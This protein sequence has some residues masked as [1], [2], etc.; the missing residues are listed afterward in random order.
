LRKLILKNYLSPGD[1]L[2][3]T[4][5]VR[6]LHLSYPD[7][8]ITDVRT[9]CPELWENN[10][11]ITELEDD[12]PDVETIECEYPL[13][14]E[15]N[16][17]PF[18]FIH[19]FR[20]FLCGRLD[21]GIK[22]T[23]FKGDVHLSDLEKSW[24]SQVDEYTSMPGTRFWIIVSG[25][26]NDF[27][28]KWWDPVRCQQVVDHFRDR[29][30]FVQCGGGS[31]SHSHPPLKGVINFVGQTDLRQMVRL[32]YHADGVVCP[33]TM[34][35]HLA[36]A[37]EP[38][39]GRPKNRACVVLAGGREPVQWES[40]PHHQYLHRNGCL[41]CCDD[42]GCW[43]CRTMALGDDAPQDGSLCLLPVKSRTGTIMPKCMDMISAEDVI[44]AI[45]QYLK[46]DSFAWRTVYADE[47]SH[48]GHSGV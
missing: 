32:M 8:F 13:I 28:T 23:A 11:Y 15:S 37:V 38:P 43:R 31:A 2:M 5:A 48:A 20:I 29:I 27:T 10:P 17:L 36:A 42:G 4:A 30:L 24:R 40:Y 18:H 3:L 41:P 7:E 9:S 6:D 16:Q 1:I 33:I 34:F 26:K 12:D 39:P 25:G 21:V 35:M 19:A 22:P 14:N 45:E 46:Y 47:I 44:N